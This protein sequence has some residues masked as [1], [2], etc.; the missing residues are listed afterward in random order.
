MSSKHSNLDLRI[1]AVTAIHSGE[2]IESVSKTYKF[3]RSTI[4]RWLQRFDEKK[5]H[6]S[7]RPE[8]RSGRPKIWSGKMQKTLLKDILKPASKFGFETDFWTCR[9]LIQH[10]ASKHGAKVSQ[11]TM[12][13]F[14]RE[15]TMT[16][17]KPEKRYKEADPAAQEEWVNTEL[18][19]IKRVARKFNAILYFEDEASIQLAP[20]LG[21]TWAP[22][23]Q[24]PI[25]RVT[26]NRGSI[27]AISAISNDGRLIFNLHRGRFRSGEIIHFLEQ[28]LKHHPRRH[29]VVV[30]DQAKPHT[31]K[32]T[33][34]FIASQKMLHVFY[35]PSRS[36]ELN[37]DEKIW[38]HLKH[39][40][41]KSHQATNLG[42]LE[43]LT[44][45]KLRKMARNPSLIRGIFLRSDIAKLMN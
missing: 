40:E 32:V 19:K 13:R 22:R 37:P 45:K 1:R 35:L 33:K 27:A 43:K 25:Q 38:N 18:P 21:K 6:D 17:Q 29:L 11:P 20:V 4:H 34:A 8:P 16:Y 39:Q 2:S 3:D 36:P 7:L 9:R 14:L 24:T 31:S 10:V 30:M 41:L 42:E 28:M 15:S 12:W 23:G 44:G 26:G 5:G